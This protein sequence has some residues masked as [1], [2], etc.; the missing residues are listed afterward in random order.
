M[1]S[2]SRAFAIPPDDLAGPS[3]GMAHVAFARQV[4]MYITATIG[5]LDHAAV[6]R[7][8][9]RDR[10]TVAH[11]CAVVED[12]LDRPE[13]EHMMGLLAGIVERQVE[14][15]TGETGFHAPQYSS[16]DHAT[17]ADAIEPDRA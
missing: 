4:A 11:A 12:R 9:N 1:E 13:L 10:T 5:G 7:L 14:L 2:V 17:A 16:F 8:F 3:R 15:V 6:G